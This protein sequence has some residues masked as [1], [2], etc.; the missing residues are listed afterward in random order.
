MSIF[1]HTPSHTQ[2]WSTEGVASWPQVPLVHS[3][4]P[5]QAPVAGCWGGDDGAARMVRGGVAGGRLLGHG[6]AFPCVR[7]GPGAPVALSRQRPGGACGVSLARTY[8][9]RLQATP[10]SMDVDGSGNGN[11]RTHAIMRWVR[12]SASCSLIGRRNLISFGLCTGFC[13]TLASWLGPGAP[14][15]M[16]TELTSGVPRGSG[17]WCHSLQGRSRG[18][19]ALMQGLRRGGPP[20]QYRGKCALEE[21]IGKAG[22]SE[23]MQ[24]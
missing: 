14:G 1:K 13:R 2:T 17:Q 6:H 10:R 12:G 22:V 11:A 7:T 8:T 4:R 20:E 18:G 19:G 23:Q 15:H 5:S 3:P 24:R 21:R 9:G 16:L